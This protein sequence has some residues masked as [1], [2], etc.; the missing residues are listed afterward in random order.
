[1]ASWS[2]PFVREVPEYTVEGE[3]II[4]SVGGEAFC[5]FTIRTFERGAAK[6]ARTIAE[7]R[8]RKADVLAFK[9]KR[10]DH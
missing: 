1:M 7:H 3:N 6:A 4:V 9:A 2:V 5:A 8:S 10:D